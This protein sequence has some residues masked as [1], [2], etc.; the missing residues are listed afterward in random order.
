MNLA[1]VARKNKKGFYRYLNWKMKVQGGIPHLVPD[2]GRLIT[3]KEK[4]EVLNK[5]FVSVFFDNCLPHSPQIFGL[6]EGN[7]GRNIPP[8]VSD[9]QVCDHLRNTSPW[10][11]MRCIPES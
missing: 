1:S 4:A 8:T 7:E 2:T 9:D 6:V 5:F 11:L 3:D 10:V